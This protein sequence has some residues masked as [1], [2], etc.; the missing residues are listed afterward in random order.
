LLLEDY[1]FTP[2]NPC[3]VQYYNSGYI[4]F[5]ERKIGITWSGETAQHVMEEHLKDTKTH[6]LKHLRIQQLAA[7]VKEWKKTGAKRYTGD[8]TDNKTGLRFL[9]AIDIYTKFALIVTAYKIKEVI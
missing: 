9:I 5:R 2:K 7:Q 4:T 3:M 6:P 8:V 1:Y